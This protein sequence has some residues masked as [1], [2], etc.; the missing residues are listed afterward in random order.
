MLYSGNSDVLV[1][2]TTGTVNGGTGNFD[3]VITE[4]G[5]SGG[6]Q[7]QQ[8]ASNTLGYFPPTLGGDASPTDGL[9]LVGYEDTVSN[10]QTFRPV[11]LVGSVIRVG[12]SADANVRVDRSA[13]TVS[14]HADNGINLT[15]DTNGNITLT[16]G[17]GGV[18]KAEK[19][20][21]LNTLVPSTDGNIEVEGNLNV[22]GNLNYVNVEDLLVNDQSITLNYGNAS[23]R[24]AFIIVDRSGTGGGTNAFI[25]WNETTH[26]WQTFDG[27]ITRDLE[28]VESV[29]DK[30]GVV[31]VGSSDIPE[32]NIDGFD[33]STANF[34]RTLDIDA[35]ITINGPRGMTFNASGTKL[36]ILGTGSGGDT[37]DTVF[38]FDVYTAYNIASAEYARQL[39][40]SANLN[41]PADI[42][43]NTNGSKMFLLNSGTGQKVHE[44][45]LSTPFDVTTGTH[46]QEFDVSAQETAP[47]GLAFNTDGTKM[48][49][50]GL[51]GDDVNEYTLSTGFDLGSTVTFV[52]SFDISTQE[53]AAY[54][55]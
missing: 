35:D 52:D 50:V 20:L 16:P 10:P 15:T 46:S 2:A 9:Y 54:K 6:V 38:E 55:C 21:H 7:T 40:V 43:F 19:A 29:N 5:S 22:Q 42:A 11:T 44:Y 47:Q 31:L 39:D 1:S 23:A 13:K 25:K 17:T 48:F 53:D 28:G 4:T 27:G 32:G 51:I 26:S 8:I 37:D 12:N 41:S 36:Y 33:I 34:A 14:M 24:D 18:I 30:T 45:A 49:I 3:R